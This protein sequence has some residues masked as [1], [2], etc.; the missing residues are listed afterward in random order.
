VKRIIFIIVGVMAVLIAGSPGPA[1]VQDIRPTTDVIPADW[2]ITELSKVT[3][4]VDDESRFYVLAWE[5]I[6][7][8]RPLRVEKCLVLRVLDKDDGFG[9]WCLAKLYRH[10][11]GN[12]PRW[13]QSMMHILNDRT[14]GE[15]VHHS[16][17]LK[18]GTG[19]AGVYAALK[20]VNWEF[21]LSEGWRRISGHVCET[22]WELA[23]GEKPSRFF[24]E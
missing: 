10:P 21:K 8:D 7:D 16:V 17:R 12:D 6:E 15:L 19:N 18:A 9:Q 2:S 3:P 5:V 20:K 23:I 1:F 22:N 4:P 24:E 13:H 11:G 14:G